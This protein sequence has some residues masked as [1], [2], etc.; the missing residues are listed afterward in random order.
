MWSS[1]ITAVVVFVRRAGE[2]TVLTAFW[3]AQ[4]QRHL[5]RLKK[6]AR[7]VTLTWPMLAMGEPFRSCSLLDNYI[8]HTH[9][10]KTL[11]ETIV[12][13]PFFPTA[14][15]VDNAFLVSILGMRSEKYFWLGLSNQRNI[16]DFVW[17]NTNTVKFTHWNA[18]MPGM[19]LLLHMKEK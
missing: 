15:R 11:I 19:R 3:W 9:Q 8:S 18:N 4:R 13:I 12:F 10:Q 7:A 16:D 2:G 5:M 6:S 1:L 14:A 17:T